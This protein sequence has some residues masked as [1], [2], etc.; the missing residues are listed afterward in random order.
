MPPFLF[1]SDPSHSARCCWE[2]LIYK[3]A[4]WK[5]ERSSAL[6]WFN[7]RLELPLRVRFRSQ[8]SIRHLLVSKR[9]QF[10]RVHTELLGCAGPWND[11]QVGSVC[12]FVWLGSM[13]GQTAG[14]PG[15]DEPE[16]FM[17][18]LIG[19]L[20]PAKFKCHIFPTYA[21]KD[22]EKTAFKCIGLEYKCTPA[23]IDRLPEGSLHIK[24]IGWKHTHWLWRSI[25]EYLYLHSRFT[26]LFA[27]EIIGG[28]Q[29][30]DETDVHFK[31]GDFSIL[32]EEK[33]RDNKRGR[34][35]WS[36]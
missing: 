24:S 12:V 20:C 3:R 21:R 7:E 6:A 32:K 23:I 11:L 29:P 16:A 4:D 8:S 26:Y 17:H 14:P 5:Y 33:K 28:Q 9:F 27:W 18:L 10:I 1:E 31:D 25:E 36:S 35:Y 19:V 2:N 30:S 15:E 22:S 34:E 13:S